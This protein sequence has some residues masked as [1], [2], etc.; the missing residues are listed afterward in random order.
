MRLWIRF[1][2]E[3]KMTIVVFG[4]MMGIFL[5]VGSLY[6][7]ENL[8]KLLYAALLVVVIGGAIGLSQGLKYVDRSRRLEKVADYF[9]QTSELFLGEI[10]GKWAVPCEDIRD[11]A[12]LEEAYTY[13]ACLVGESGNKAKAEYGE[14][15]AD[16]NDYY[17][18]WTHQIKVPISAMKLLLEGDDIQNRPFLLREELFKIEQYV[19]MVLGFQRLESLAQDLVLQEHG[20]MALL[21]QVVRKFSVLFIN[22]GLTLELRET[23]ARIVTDEKW[24]IFC[25]EQILS[26]SIKYTRQGSIRIWAQ[27][28]GDTVIL[29][30]E[31]TGIGIRREDLPRIFERGFTGYNGRM[32]KRSTGI[33]L[34]LCRRVFDHL[35][36][37]VEVES[38]VGEG[39]RMMMT[40]VKSAGA[41]AE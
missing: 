39:T 29:T 3:K 6:H 15:I 18:M 22:K 12:T 36:I 26:N 14:R 11:C 40:L 19:E 27:E 33:G 28:R 34:Y 7:I 30:V 2:R 38:R 9:E 41:G 37:G 1:L 25:M 13:L 31:D 8:D 17:V 20:L 24:F 32:D 21:R 16:H 35:G 4:G 23:K 5:A 10:Y